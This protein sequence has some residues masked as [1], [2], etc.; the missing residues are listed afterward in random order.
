MLGRRITQSLILVASLMLFG[1]GGSAVIDT[2]GGPVSVG[3]TFIFEGQSFIVTSV[4]TDG[5]P[6]TVSAHQ[7]AFLKQILPLL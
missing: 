5:S 2:G 3:D 7:A 4:A 6:I 1:C